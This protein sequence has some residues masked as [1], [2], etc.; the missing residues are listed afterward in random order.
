MR[1][2]P[3]AGP[4]LAEVLS[5]LPT[6]YPFERDVRF[7]VFSKRA[8]LEGT[9][10]TIS[11]SGGELTFASDQA[12]A[13]RQRQGIEVSVSWPVLL[14]NRLPLKLVVRGRVVSVEPGKAVIS[15]R[16]HEFRTSPKGTTAA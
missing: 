1:L 12:N 8:P 13:L 16:G 10:T 6:A 15:I 9:G 11:I 4:T 3:T 5:R 2:L 7:R 14:D